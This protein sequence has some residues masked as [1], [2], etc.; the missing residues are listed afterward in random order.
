MVWKVIHKTITFQIVHWSFNQTV[1]WHLSNDRIKIP[2]MIKR[3]LSRSKDTKRDRKKKRE[4]AIE[5]ALV[6]R[7]KL[8]RKKTRLSWFWFTITIHNIYLDFDLD[9]DRIPVWFRPE[10]RMYRPS[11]DCWVDKTVYPFFK[12]YQLIK[13]LN[14]PEEEEVIRRYFSTFM[15]FID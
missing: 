7:F 15:I 12:N 11:K 1:W 13:R 10:L 8:V 6:R 3:L 4:R 14:R 9:F 2:N 5:A